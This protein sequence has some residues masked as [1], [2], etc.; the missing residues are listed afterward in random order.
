[1]DEGV[2]GSTGSV[3]LMSEEQ[4]ANVVAR[5]FAEELGIASVDADDH[6][7]FLGADSLNVERV[8]TVIADHFSIDLSTA[9]ILDF[10]TPRALAHL[11]APMLSSQTG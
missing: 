4:L 7:L 9:T 11:I 10:P 2:G 3:A 8:I 1:L 5:F 6:F